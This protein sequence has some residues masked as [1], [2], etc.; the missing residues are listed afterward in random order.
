MDPHWVSEAVPLI[1]RQRIRLLQHHHR[2]TD[3]EA[4][5]GGTRRAITHTLQQQY[6]RLAVICMGG[7]Q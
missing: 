3:A 2:L 6:G 7:W 4:P 5:S 1:R